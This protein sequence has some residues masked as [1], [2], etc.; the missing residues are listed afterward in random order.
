[1]NMVSAL[2]Q[3]MA[4]G[5]FSL[6]WSG[7]AGAVILACLAALLG[8]ASVVDERL[9]LFRDHARAAEAS[10]QIAIVEI[11][12][13]SLKRI[14]DWP[15]PRRTHAALIDKLRAGGATTIA[16]DVDF[17]AT[18]NPVDDA[19]L[20]QALR[21]AGGAVVLP[22]FRQPVSE[23]S[24]LFAENLPIAAFR[25]H[26]FLGSVNVQPDADGQLRRYSYGTV[27]AGVPRPSIA[28]LL[29]GSEGNIEKSF[30]VDTAIDPGSIPRISALDVLDGKLKTVRGRTVIIGATAIEMGDRYVVP[31]H[32]VLPG[33]VVQA[34]AAETLIQG[35]ANPDWGPW[36][37]LLFAISAMALGIRA[38]RYV[39]TS[40]FVVATLAVVPLLLEMVHAGSVQIGPALVLIMLDALLVGLL[41]V[42][43]T[44]TESRLIDAATGLPNGRA[45]ARRSRGIGD[46]YVAVV[47]LQQFDEIA[48]VLGTD[49]RALLMKQVVNRLLVAFPQAEIHVIEAGIIAWI[50]KEP[51]EAD[52]AEAGAAL[53]RAPVTLASRAV[54]VTPVFGV[55]RGVGDEADHLLARANIAARQA[56]ASGQRWAFESSTL[57]SDAD[58]SIALI[59]D[60]EAA[61]ANDEIYVVYQ[62]KWDV[63]TARVAG[64][65]ALVRWHHPAFGPLSPDEFIPVLENNGQMRTLTLAI[66]DI[67]AAQLRAWHDHGY[68]IGIAINIS[69]ALVDDREFVA[70]IT[71]RLA[72]LGTLASHITLEITESATIGSTNAA[73]AA[74]TTFRSFGARIS[75]DDYGTGQ[76]TLAYLK[77]FPADEIKI[78]K[79]FVTDMV[80]NKSDQIVVRSTIELAHQLG[81]SVVA[82]GVE[83]QQC[84]D[85][86][87]DYGCDIV[88]GWVIGRPV[89]ADAFMQL[90]RAA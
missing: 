74:L 72:A 12:A 79:S 63:A 62:A 43:R 42:R 41:H 27:T 48:A 83:D 18:S 1:M 11:D 9:H 59:A 5:A 68:G 3:N 90:S 82:E 53:F 8:S 52:E 44:L 7:F 56:Q 21:R 49:D 87:R 73:V 70:A 65:E 25:D 39:G 77:S 14:A 20:A 60:V 22:T 51:I 23:G 85:Y 36:P 54:V 89:R 32:G 75:I 57:S 64:A 15:W 88:Q 46:T 71:T 66:V 81:F 16:F 37:A 28:A 4:A 69:A 31:G 67:C 58:R 2:S 24:Q 40:V 84:L 38:R 55:S 45:L 17:S 19:M 35:S 80:R 50:S 6:R 33:V 26:A 13:R 34:L 76:A 86:L 78:D 29:A 30:R 10:G 47:R 61:I